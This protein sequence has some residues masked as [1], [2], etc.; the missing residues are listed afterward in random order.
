MLLFLSKVH[1]DSGVVMQYRLLSI[2]LLFKPTFPCH[3]NV[4]LTTIKYFVQHDDV[5]RLYRHWTRIMKS[6]S[7]LQCFTVIVFLRNYDSN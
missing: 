5:L 7:P 6:I 4:T 3:D 2:N 1:D